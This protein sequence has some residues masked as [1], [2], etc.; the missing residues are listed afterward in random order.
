MPKQ[1]GHHRAIQCELGADFGCIG[2]LR[3]RSFCCMW[4]HP[5]DRNISSRNRKTLSCTEN[6][7][8]EAAFRNVRLPV[9]FKRFSGSGKVL[10][11]FLQGCACIDASRASWELIVDA[12]KSCGRWLFNAY[13]FIPQRAILLR[14]MGKRV[15]A[16]FLDEILISLLHQNSTYNSAKPHTAPKAPNTVP[17]KTKYSSKNTT[18]P[19]RFALKSVL[20]T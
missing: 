7:R 11:H 14:K 19:P 12:L 4:F 2:K 20:G 10:K 3:S 5:A 1:I 8:F 17:P 15:G 16:F 18:H 6:I 13:R 9:R